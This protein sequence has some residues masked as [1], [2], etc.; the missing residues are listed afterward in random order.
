MDQKQIDNECCGMKS[1][2]DWQDFGGFNVAEKVPKSCLKRIEL[3]R[4]SRKIMTTSVHTTGCLVIEKKKNLVWFYTFAKF[5]LVGAIVTLVAFFMS[6]LKLKPQDQQENQEIQIQM[7]A[8]DGFGEMNVDSMPVHFF[9]MLISLY[10][11][12]TVS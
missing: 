2:S 1:S 12:T 4:G 9:I 8:L 11:Y 5:Y 7:N 10:R 6:H 3:Y